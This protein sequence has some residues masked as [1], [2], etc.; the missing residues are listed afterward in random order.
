MQSQPRDLV[1]V[2]CDICHKSLTKPGLNAHRKETHLFGSF[3]CTMCDYEGEQP[4]PI[5]RHVVEKHPEHLR[6]CRSQMG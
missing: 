4:A 6:Y 1:R 5:T 2:E 3:P